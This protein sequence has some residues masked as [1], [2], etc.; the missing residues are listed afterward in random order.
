MTNI[1][2]GDYRFLNPSS[3]SVVKF[4]LNLFYIRLPSNVKVFFQLR[5]YIKLMY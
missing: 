3:L 1:N 4:F 2:N 5:I